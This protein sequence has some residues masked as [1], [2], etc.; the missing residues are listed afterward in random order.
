ME[1]IIDRIRDIKPV[2]LGKKKAIKT[3]LVVTEVASHMESVGYRE[4]E[5][6]DVV[7]QLGA[8]SSLRYPSDSP[9]KTSAMIRQA[10]KMICDLIY[11][12]LR[13]GLRGLQ[14]DIWRVDDLE[15]RHSME[16]S[17]NDLLA[18]TEV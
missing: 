17:I 12:D 6:Y 10:Q 3:P 13:K 11:G 5:Y 15:L 8:H 9:E 18:A 14:A 1:N 16:K 4:A 7:V 2:G